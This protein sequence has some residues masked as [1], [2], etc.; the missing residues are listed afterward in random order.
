[1]A[2]TAKY[3][4]SVETPLPQPAQAYLVRDEVIRDFKEKLFG[5]LSTLEDEGKL[6]DAEETLDM[7]ATILD[8]RLL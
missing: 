8:H 7:L 3:E 4:S 6:Q 1:M 2:A 5:D